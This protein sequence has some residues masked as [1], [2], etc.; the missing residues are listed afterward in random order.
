MALTLTTALPSI[1]AML[2]GRSFRLGLVTCLFTGCLL[3]CAINPTPRTTPTPAAPAQQRDLSEP[4]QAA[5]D[6]QD[7][8][9]IYDSAAADDLWH[10]IIIELRMTPPTPGH[11]KTAMQHFA[12]NADFVSAATQ[13]AEPYL[14]FIYQEVERRRL[15]FE[16][17]LLPIIESGYAPRATSPEGAAGIWQI[18]TSTGHRF[19]LHQSRWYDGR[20]D[21]V[22]STGAALD[23]LQEL[24]D[25]FFGDWLLA[26][27]AYNCGAR[28]VERAIERNRR[29]GQPTDFWSLDLPRETEHYVPRLL[30]LVEILSAPEAHAV[31]IAQISDA[32]YFE[33]VDVGGGLDL[34]RVIEWSGMSADAFEALNPGFRTRFSIEGAPNIVLVRKG[35]SAAVASA[36]S[37]LSE[38]DRRA[39]RRHVVVAGETLSHIAAHTGV[40]V[41]E[42]K[43]ANGM[44]SNRIRAGQ[45]LLIPSPGTI[46]DAGD[47]FNTEVASAA[48]HVI[49]R[50][51]TLWDIARSYGT[52]TDAIA[53]AN[54]MALDTTL[55]PG[56]ELR[57]PSHIAEPPDGKPLHYEVKRGDSLWT[58]SRQFKVSVAD[59]KKWNRLSGKRYLQPGQTLVVYQSTGDQQQKI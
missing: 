54:G 18:M 23:Y 27:A 8:T 47:A 2:G 30:A 37:V 50:G 59:L 49:A 26:F 19:H 1:A 31:D 44:R 25:Q 35:H 53:A 17:T 36:I 48:V 14:H 39:P 43:R 58:I 4:D 33:P 38:T 40:A 13:R 22:A 32:P 41:T 20:R 34:N 24:R 5:S 15:P 16:V 6:R 7:P 9:R 52:T 3:G 45:D 12:R 46:N 29:A 51:D 56:Q 21:V 57:L 11:I 28:T 42:I 55:R 10:R